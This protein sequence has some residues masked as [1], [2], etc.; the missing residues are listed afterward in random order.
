MPWPTWPPT[1]SMPISIPASAT[2]VGAG[3]RWKPPARPGAG[4]APRIH[5]HRSPRHRWV[6]GLLA[7]GLLVGP[8]AVAAALAIH[9]RELQVA[10]RAL[11]V[12]LRLLEVRAPEDFEGAFGAATTGRAAGLLVLPDGLADAHRT[13]IVAL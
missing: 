5:G 11:G 3:P 1:W 7:L 10:G 13:R 8:L 9:R 2:R 4:C 12:Q 6:V